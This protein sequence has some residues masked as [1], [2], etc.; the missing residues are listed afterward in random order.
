MTGSVKSI[1]QGKNGMIAMVEGEGQYQQ[2]KFNVGEQTKIVT[3]EGDELSTND[4]K[5]GTRLEVFYGPRM[6]RSLPPMATAKKIVV[7]K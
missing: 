4:I 3:V 1:Q 2:I 5:E 6:T 7:L